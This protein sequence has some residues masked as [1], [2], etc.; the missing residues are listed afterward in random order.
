MILC[1]AH[2]ITP[3]GHDCTLPARRKS[4]VQLTSQ[5]RNS[6]AHPYLD[7]STAARFFWW[8]DPVA[9]TH[10]WRA[11]QCHI[12]WRISCRSQKALR[13]SAVRFKPWGRATEILICDE[14]GSIPSANFGAAVYTATHMSR[15]E[16]AAAV[17]CSQRSGGA[18]H[19]HK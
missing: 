17:K 19:S 13:D 16:T 4:I 6:T 7:H 9:M 11:A 5:H 2:E 18:Q 15:K 3:R 1:A 10:E 14:T 12:I 8:R